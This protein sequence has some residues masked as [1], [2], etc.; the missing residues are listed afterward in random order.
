MSG[1]TGT[2]EANTASS[3]GSGNSL[4]KQKTGVDLEFRSISAGTGITIV[5]GDTWTISSSTA[6]T[7]DG[8]TVLTN[9]A[10]QDITNA[11]FQN[12]TDLN[13]SV[14]AG[15]MYMIDCALTFYCTASANNQGRFAVDAG[16][17]SGRD[18]S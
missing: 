2:G 6:T 8:W 7:V 1:S 4:Y 16:T 12:S 5:T 9:S 15:G 10:D 17:L 11:T 13:F 18:V 14:D 3:V